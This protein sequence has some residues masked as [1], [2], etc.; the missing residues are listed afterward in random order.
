M[1]ELPGDMHTAYCIPDV[2]YTIDYSQEPGRH[3][4]YSLKYAL[5]ICIT[6]HLGI[7]VLLRKLDFD[8]YRR[9]R[10]V[11]AVLI[12]MEEVCMFP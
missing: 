1:I 3:V 9:L 8:L 12:V 10:V 11:I 4:L 2:K 6:F 7:R 5:D